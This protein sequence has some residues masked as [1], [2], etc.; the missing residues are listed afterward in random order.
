VVV[1]VVIE[2]RKLDTTKRLIQQYKGYVIVIEKRKPNYTK[3]LHTSVA[4]DSRVNNVKTIG[5]N[6]C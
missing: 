2:K 5:V 1:V 4:G 6:E 3:R